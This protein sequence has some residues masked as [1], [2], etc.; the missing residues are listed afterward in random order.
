MD[1]A[2]SLALSSRISRLRRYLQ[3]RSRE[4]KLHSGYLDG[5][6][7]LKATL[8]VRMFTLGQSV[9]RE[10]DEFSEDAETHLLSFIEYLV[11]YDFGVIH[12]VFF[13]NSFQ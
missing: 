4:T 3:Y 6:S 2:V 13:S 10:T 11:N 8:T 12:S 9:C 5:T 7:H 1:R